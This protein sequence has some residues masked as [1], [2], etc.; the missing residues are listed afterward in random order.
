MRALRLGLR[1][2][3]PKMCDIDTLNL[4][5][6]LFIISK[7]LVLGPGHLPLCPRRTREKRRPLSLVTAHQFQ[8]VQFIYFSG[9]LPIYIWRKKR[10]TFYNIWSKSHYTNL[11]C[12][13]DHDQKC[14]KSTW[15]DA[16]IFMN[17]MYRGTIAARS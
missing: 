8:S 7:H 2:P 6:L 17:C 15:H 4:V 1:P 9:F 11:F 3:P 10:H 5:L 12:T 13:F 16:A 14:V